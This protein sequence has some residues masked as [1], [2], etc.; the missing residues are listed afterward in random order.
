MSNPP[1]AIL[2]TMLF[3]VCVRPFTPSAQ[4]YPND[5]GLPSWG[6]LCFEVGTTG[7]S[8]SEVLIV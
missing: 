6:R 3:D 5:A 7:V 2:A 1:S 4:L 8:C